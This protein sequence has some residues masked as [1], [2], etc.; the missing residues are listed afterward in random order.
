M[1]HW[2]NICKPKSEG[3]L[4]IRKAADMNKALLAKLNWRLVKEHDK[5][6]VRFVK[7]KYKSDLLLATNTIINN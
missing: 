5:L 4:G 2:S 6:W 3:G 1:I 7:S